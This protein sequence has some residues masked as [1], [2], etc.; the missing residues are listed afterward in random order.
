MREQH[1]RKELLV[2]LW[3]LAT[4]EPRIRHDQVSGAAPVGFHGGAGAWTRGRCLLRNL[5]NGSGCA[6]K[7]MHLH[8]KSFQGDCC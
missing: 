1:L 7:S 3:L 6:G 5:R 4:S 2:D 8:C